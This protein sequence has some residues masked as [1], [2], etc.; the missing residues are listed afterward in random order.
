METTR[1]PITD[2]NAFPSDHRQRSY[3][4]LPLHRDLMISVVPGSLPGWDLCSRIVLNTGIIREAAAVSPADSPAE[5]FYFPK[6]DWHAL[7]AHD[8]TVLG[9]DPQQLAQSMAKSLLIFS[10]PNQLYS[11]FWDLDLSTLLTHPNT[12]HPEY[13]SRYRAFISDII[14]YMINDLGFSISGDCSC[15]TIINKPGLRSTRYNPKFEQYTGL[16]IDNLGD[17][18]IDNS[19]LLYT[20]ACIN[21]GDEVNYISFINLTLLRIFEVLNLEQTCPSIETASWASV[22][23]KQFMATFPTYPIVKIGLAPGEGYIVPAGN[24]IYDRDTLGKIEPDINLSIRA[25]FSLP[26]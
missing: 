14:T 17:F 6:D 7:T 19:Y 26:M 23:A 22:V 15:T 8:L 18:P 12:S 24:I 1:R 25:I 16:D 21:L 2:W 13:S 4:T 20:T 9:T 11:R 3:A 5:A 10:I